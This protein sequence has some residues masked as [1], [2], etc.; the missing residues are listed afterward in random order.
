MRALA[1]YW[2]V[3]ATAQPSEG[4]DLQTVASGPAGDG[5]LWCVVYSKPRRESLVR[6]QLQLKGVRVF[7]PRCILPRNRYKRTQRIVA[8]FPNYLFV[9]IRVPDECHTVL[10]TPG[11][12]RLVGTRDV[13]TPLDD[14]VV[15]F[16]LQSSSPDGIV[17]ARWNLTA[18]QEVRMARGPFQGLMAIIQDPPDAKG[19]VRVLMDFFRRRAVRIS[20]PAHWVESGWVV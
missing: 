4:P 2:S 3:G 11:V 1:G 8:L 6:L 12:K 10:W 13:P 17:T 19:R 15:E 20:V 14:E 16:L 9:R 7:F 18:G 5:R